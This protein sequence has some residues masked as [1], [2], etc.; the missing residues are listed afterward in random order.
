M[1]PSS[2][3]AKQPR[4]DPIPWISTT[5]LVSKVGHPMKGYQ[6]IIKSVLCKQPTES[7]L[8]VV[9]HLT[10]LDPSSSYKTMVLDYDN[11]IKAQYVDFG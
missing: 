10:H 7:G 9:A 8:H 3:S 2:S 1:Q 4:N 5:I 11:V 6:G